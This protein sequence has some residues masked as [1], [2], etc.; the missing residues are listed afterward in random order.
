MNMHEEHAAWARVVRERID[1]RQ[2]ELELGIITRH[3][4]DLDG[5]QELASEESQDPGGWEAA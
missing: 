1:E 5:R 2:Q 3:R 4:I